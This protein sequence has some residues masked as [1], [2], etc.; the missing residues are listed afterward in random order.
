ME[1]INRDLKDIRENA[2]MVALN[3]T[4]IVAETDINGII[5]YA[6]DKFLDISEYQK[7]EVIGRTHKIINSGVHPKSFMEDLWK[8]IKSG[9]VWRGEICNKSKS[10]RIY[11]VD[12][13]I[14]PIY[15]TDNKII[16]FIAIRFEIT[17]KKMLAEKLMAEVKSHQDSLSLLNDAKEKAENANHAKDSFLA[18]MSHEIRT[19]LTGILG[20]MELLSLTTLDEEQHETL[21]IAWSSGRGL[22]RIVNDILDWSKI[23]EGKLDLAPRPTSIEQMLQEV[24]NTYSPVASAKDLNLWHHSDSRLSST[25]NFDS[26]RMS[27]ILNNFVSN[28]IKFTNQGEI[29][30]RANLKEKLEGKERICFSVKD[31]G[32]GISKETQKKLFQLYHQESADTARMYGGTGLGLA[33]CK[34][35]TE[36]MNGVLHFES[37]INLGSTFSIT[38]TLPVSNVPAEIIHS[39][40]LDVV[41]RAIKPLFNDSSCSPLILAV[42]D[43]PTNRD[44]I[45]KQIK[46]L[47]LRSELA[48][49]GRE[50]LDLWQ[51][52]RFALI[53][54][55]CHMPEM[56]GY[57]LT[58]SIRKIEVR[59]NLKRTPIIAWTANALAEESRR[60]QNA[61]MDDLLTKPVDLD[62]LKKMLLKWVLGKQSEDFQVTL[63]QAGEMKDS[64]LNLT[65][66]KKTITDNSLIKKM[67]L[68]FHSQVVIDINILKT[69]MDEGNL[70]EIIDM[71]HRIRGACQMVGA[72]NLAHTCAEI[73]REG[74]SNNLEMA[75]SFKN[76]LSN[77][78]AQLDFYCNNLGI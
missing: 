9:K 17:E 64:P 66:L 13:C 23:E 5:T 45:G 21:N 76:K 56:D 10:G 52:G 54:S 20:M 46:L 31:T 37:E 22:L 39:R 41:K 26:L 12:T 74:K 19:P 75:R 70:K 68:D 78:F 16:N 7:E 55:D 47:G 3:K 48:E 58:K 63:K 33:I 4:A 24:V 59:L 62:Q 29:E 60:C 32:V 73:E 30:L 14:A 36:L 67:L 27:Q 65:F 51:T 71:A 2:L 28:S 38:L 35:L 40:S 53:I 6:N 72:N 77:D 42:D 50:A 8:T 11:W 1:P 61:G 57:E 44:L 69:K 34:R 49:S 25:H 18:T 43:H 15:G